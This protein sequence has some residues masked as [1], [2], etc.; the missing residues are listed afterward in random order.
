MNKGSA[1]AIKINL[2]KSKLEDPC[3]ITPTIKNIEI[4]MIRGIIIFSFFIILLSN[5]YITKESRGIKTNIRDPNPNRITEFSNKS[6][7]KNR[8]SF[9]FRKDDFFKYKY[10]NMYKQFSDANCPSVSTW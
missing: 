6:N 1:K 7:F 9:L 4:D 5:K 8:M 3:L 10:K 2:S